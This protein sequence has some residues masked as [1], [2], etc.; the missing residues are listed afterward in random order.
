[1]RPLRALRL[2][3]AALLS[4]LAAGTAAGCGSIGEAQQ[5]VDRARLVNNL[6]ERL[7]RASQLTYTAEYQLSGGV[8][9]TIAQAQHPLRVAYTYP[10]GKLMILADRTVNCSTGTTGTTCTLTVPAT[11]ATDAAGSLLSV[12]GPRG[13]LPPTA[14]VGLLTAASLSTDATITQQD[15]TVAGEHATCV[16]VDGVE[17]A[18]SSGFTACITAAGVLGSFTGSVDGTAFDVSLVRFQETVAEDAFDL[19]AGAHVV[20]QR[21]G[22]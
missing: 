9:A 14:V 5:V 16:K 11:A 1:M 19:P 15:T 21:P 20:D 17:N 8:R 4:T 2:A 7:D 22:R 10:G 6:A 13:L 18:A 12:V 3:A